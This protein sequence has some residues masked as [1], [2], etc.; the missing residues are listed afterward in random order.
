M[1]DVKNFF[2]S[3][4][5]MWDNPK[6]KGVTQ[7]IFWV[8]F[9]AIVAIMFRSGKS[10]DTTNKTNIDSNTNIS[11]KAIKEDSSVVSYEYEYIYTENDNVINISGTHY[12]NKEKFTLNGVSYYSIS[13]NYYNALTNVEVNIDYAIDEWSYNNIKN[14]TDNNPYSNLTKFKAG[15]EK[16]EYNI[17]KE[18]Y[19]KYY[20]RTYPNDIIITINKTDS[21][22]IEATINYGFGSVSIKYTNIN[23]IENLDI[24]GIG[25]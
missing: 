16:Y 11:N 5:S 15:I 20:N 10:S 21:N 22:I 17:S 9:F 23:E 25:S 18:I 14:I 12:D 2:K 6:L 13:D 3:L 1:K 7:L 19:N 8:I 24:K 4:K